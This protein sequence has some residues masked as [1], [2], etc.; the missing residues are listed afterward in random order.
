MHGTHSWGPP[1]GSAWKYP[2][3][4]ARQL[5]AEEQAV[6]GEGQ[7][8]QRSPAR[9]QPR[10]QEVQTPPSQRAQPAAAHGAHEPPESP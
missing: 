5:A 2:S 10:L 3:A 8:R 4:Q 9:Y 7:A 6:H 1:R